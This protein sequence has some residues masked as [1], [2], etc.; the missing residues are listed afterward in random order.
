[1]NIKEYFRNKITNLKCWIKK[2]FL[3]KNSLEHLENFTKQYCVLSLGFDDIY[4][5]SKNMKR[6]CIFI[7]NWAF[8]WFA[9]GFFHHLFCVTKCFR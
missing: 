3:L 8:G 1:M 4:Y 2:Y 6:F 7:V 5:G 9:V